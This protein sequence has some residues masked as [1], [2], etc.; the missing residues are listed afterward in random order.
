MHPRF[1]SGVT[2]VSVE[3]LRT[4]NDI[5]Q[6]TLR[7][8]GAYKH[9]VCSRMKVKTPLCNYYPPPSKM[10]AWSTA[11]VLASITTSA[12]AQYTYGYNRNRI[13]GGAIAGIV[14]GE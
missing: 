8:P 1:R 4:T 13:A 9:R 11:I 5:V 2:C 14:I 12:S 10:L 7:L 6:S 3:P